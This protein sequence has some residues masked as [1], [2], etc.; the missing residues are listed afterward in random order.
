MDLEKN[1]NQ[2]HQN[3]TTSGNSIA[4]LV[5]GILSVIIPYI[6]FILGIIGIVISRKAFREIAQNNYD[7]KGMAIAG[8]TTSIVGCAL[9]GLIIIILLIIG[10]SAAIFSNF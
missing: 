4:S 9:Y 1:N 2:Y 5:L 6:G 10:G 8:L 3:R 7:G